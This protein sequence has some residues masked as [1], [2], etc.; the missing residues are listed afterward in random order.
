MLTFL[1]SHSKYFAKQKGLQRC[2]PREGGE[3]T[4]SFRGPAY[5][6]P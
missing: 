4:R 6:Q 1:I 2:S 3:P 5:P